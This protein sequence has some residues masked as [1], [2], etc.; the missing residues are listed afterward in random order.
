M[1]LRSSN[2]LIELGEFLHVMW[3]LGNPLIYREFC[4]VLNAKIVKHFLFNEHANSVDSQE[5]IK[6][7]LIRAPHIARLPFNNLSRHDH[8]KTYGS[9]LAAA[10]SK[11]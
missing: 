5:S 10:S 3:I 11:A 6:S 4:K 1:K 2:P 8:V 7:K 9:H